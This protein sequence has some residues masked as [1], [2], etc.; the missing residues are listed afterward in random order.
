MRRI[1]S[2]D[3]ILLT[4]MDVQVIQNDFQR[5][6]LDHVLL[7]FQKSRLALHECKT[8]QSVIKM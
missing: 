8:L 4:Q 5:G 1:I 2:V 6:F 3:Y 7:H